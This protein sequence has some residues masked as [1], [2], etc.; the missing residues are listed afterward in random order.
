MILREGH[1]KEKEKETEEIH[2][3]YLTSG[4]ASFLWVRNFPEPSLCDVR[5]RPSTS[6]NWSICEK[7]QLSAI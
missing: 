2:R 1:E 5:L 3:S 4:I 6:E 7:L